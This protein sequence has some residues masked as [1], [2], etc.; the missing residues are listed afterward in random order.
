MGPDAAA[1]PIRLFTALTR[2]LRDEPMDDAVRARAMD[3]LT[4]LA[5]QTQLPGFSPDVQRLLTLAEQDARLKSAVAPFVAPLL[6]WSHAGRAADPA[7][8]SPLAR[9]ADACA[10]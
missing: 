8:V 9:T 10:K 5:G 4:H 2:A 1:T 7:D 3:L 6:A